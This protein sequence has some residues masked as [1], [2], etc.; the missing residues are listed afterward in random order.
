VSETVGPQS[1][2]PAGYA[3]DNPAIAR[4]MKAVAGDVARAQADP[5]RPVCHFRA[6]AQWMNDPNGTIYHDG[7]YHLFYQH[8]PYGDSWGSMHWGHARSRDLVYWEH[9]PIAL[10]PSEE[11][12][13][14]HCYSGCAATNRLAEPMLFYTSVPPEKGRHQQWAALGDADWINWRKHPANPLLALETHG[15]PEFEGDWRDPFVFRSHGRTFLAVGAKLTEADGGDPAV[16]LYEAT[17]PALARWSYRGI[18]LRHPREGV[19]FCECPNFFSVGGRW[20]LLTSTF[21]P[22]EYFVGDFDPETCAFKWQATGV[23]DHTMQFYASNVLFGPAGRCILLGWVREFP[24][25]QGWNGCLS[26]PRVLSIGADGRPVQKPL[27]ELSALRGKHAGVADM[28]LAEESRTVEGLSAAS[29]EALVEI[30]PGSAERFGVA[31]ALEGG[32]ELAR[33]SC[34]GGELDVAG[35]RFPFELRA[36]EDAL[37]VHLFLDRSVLDVFVNERECVTRVLEHGDEEAGVQLFA[38]GGAARAR[39]ADVWE[40]KPIW[41]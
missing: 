31:L 3:G 2:L 19:G 26:L 20:V 14:G 32:Q 5:A 34:E 1:E 28:H 40:L 37:R 4:A 6:P 15:G 24:E 39:S 38:E 21:A 12:G 18:L 41:R 30:E 16:A 29:L 10:W 22:V 35:A 23:I 17:A 27:P 13:E 36:D 8:N 11:K 25:G 7:W 9:L 33:V